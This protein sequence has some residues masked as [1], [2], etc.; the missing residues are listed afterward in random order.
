MR[1]AADAITVTREQL[2]QLVWDAPLK[3]AARRFGI[4]GT[5][6]AKICDRLLIP[7]PPPGYWQKPAS[8]R[9]PRPP[10]TPGP[11]GFRDPISIART[12]SLSR[13][14]RTRMSR[15]AR[16]E[17][18]MAIAADIVVAEGMH[19]VS[20][21]IVARRAGIS[22]AQAHNCF[23]GLVDL[24]ASLAKRELAAVDDRRRS[25][26]DR[27][28]D[29]LAR[30]TLSIVTYLHQVSRRGALIQTLINNPDVR[31]ALRTDYRSRRAETASAIGHRLAA[32]YGVA[33]DI[34]V[35][36]TGIF[37]AISL[38]AGRLLARQNATVEEA[39]RLTLAIVLAGNRAVF[40]RNSEWLRG[41]ETNGV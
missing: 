7:S 40:G 17:Q 11:P 4:S 19:A 24:L 32:T 34:A 16:R 13:R 29:D 6:L 3:P 36:A 28:S 22:E 25:E 5:G 1:E 10:L 30:T 14:P 8:E 35:V 39:E 9:P 2:F 21:K 37:S 41:E 33:P 26:V 18:L 38:R 27:G 31:R 23:S 20:M 15:E 12:R